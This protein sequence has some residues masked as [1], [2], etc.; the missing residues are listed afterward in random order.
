MID[1]IKTYILGDIAENCYVF[2][3]KETGAVAVVDPGAYSQELVDAISELGGKIELILLTHGHFD[4]MG[5]ALEL[6]RKFGG[7]IVISAEQTF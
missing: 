1:N 3:D 5:Y 7:K 6:Q 4:H 2:T